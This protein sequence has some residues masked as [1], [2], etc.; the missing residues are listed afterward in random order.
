VSVVSKRFERGMAKIRSLIFQYG[1]KYYKN[2][3]ILKVAGDNLEYTV[4]SFTGADL[5]DNTDV[6]VIEGSTLPGSITAKRDLILALYNQG[7]I[8]DPLD[9]KTKDKVATLLEFGDLQGVWRD[10]GLDMSQIER[11]LSLIRQG[12]RP[13]VHKLDNH[14][15]HIEQKNSYRKTE[16]FLKLAPENQAI[17]LAN[18]EQHLE[19]LA[20]IAGAPSE[21]D[22]F[23]EG[24]Q[25]MIQEE[26]MLQEQEAIA[27]NEDQPVQ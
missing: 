11:D 17:L 5:Y 1:H 26:A 14:Q 4:K 25:Q 15:L 24:P 3:R 13:D 16:D 12:I 18:I 8:G 7:I 23:L 2:E 22:A 27:M 19:E 9:P 20:T 10:Y 6:H 21:E